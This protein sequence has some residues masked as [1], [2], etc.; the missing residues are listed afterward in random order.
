MED[1][2]KQ[3]VQLAYISKMHKED[4]EESFRH[5]QKYMSLY[6]YIRV[7]LFGMVAIIYL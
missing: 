6:N 1:Q 3:E 5:Y 4:L 2:E 7:A